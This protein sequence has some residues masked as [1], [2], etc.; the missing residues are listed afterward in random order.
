[1]Q[2]DRDWR[3]SSPDPELPEV[4][5]LSLIQTD[6]TMQSEQGRPEKAG[7]QKQPE[8]RAPIQGSR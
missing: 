4:N 3:K 5:L 8:F 7:D 6:V 2:T 1:M